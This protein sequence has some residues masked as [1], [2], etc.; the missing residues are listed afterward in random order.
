MDR[1]AVPAAALLGAV[2]GPVVMAAY[3]NANPGSHWDIRPGE[4]AARLRRSAAR[5]R[6]RVDAAFSA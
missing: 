5:L 6:S 4:A 3:W 2:T 1:F